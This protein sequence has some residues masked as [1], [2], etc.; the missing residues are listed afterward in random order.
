ML[1]EHGR[2]KS[3][4]FRP[5]NVEDGSKNNKNPYDDVDQLTS[6]DIEENWYTMI[7]C[8]CVLNRTKFLIFFYINNIPGYW[9][10]RTVR[11]KNRGHTPVR[12][13]FLKFLM[14][15]IRDRDTL[16]FYYHTIYEYHYVLI[17]VKST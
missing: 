8:V 3:P 12:L 17:R 7:E 6:N 11:Y 10:L 5:I 2:Y 13:Q 16:F 15:I 1:A 9:G 14:A 4:D